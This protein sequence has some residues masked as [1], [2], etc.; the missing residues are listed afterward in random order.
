MNGNLPAYMNQL[1]KAQLEAVEHEG[2][3]LLILAGAGS[4]KTRVITT[5]IAYL[6]E[7]KQYNPASILAVTFTNKAAAEMHNRVTGM[8]PYASGVLV[9]TF[10]SFGAWLLRRNGAAIGM[11]RSFT[12]YDDEDMITLLRTIYEKKKRNELK[13]YA[14]MISL[15]KD[16]ALTPEDNLLPITA[17][18][19]FPSIYAAYNQKLRELGNA[20]FGDLIAR[21]IELLDNNPEIL[22]RLHQRFRTVLVDEYQDSNVAQFELL[23]RL[24]GGGTYLCVVG[25]DD[26][27]IYRFRGAEVQNIIQFPDIFPDTTVIR[28][29]EN[30]RSTEPILD[31]ASSVVEH[32]RGRLGKRLWTRKKGGEKAVVRFFEN[33]EQEVAYCAELVRTGPA[34][35]TAILYRTNAQSRSFEIYFSRHNIPYRL[36]GS[37]SFY[38][39]E[40]VKDALALVTL[41]LNPNDEVAFRRVVNKP[42]RGIGAASL[43]KIIAYAPEARGDLLESC[44]KALSGLS[45]KAARGVKEFLH[46]METVSAELEERSLAE[47]VEGAVRESGILEYHLEQDKISHTQKAMNVEEL[48]NAAA[49]YPNGRE[50]LIEFLEA[51]EL[52]RSRIAAREEEGPSGVT[53]I[54]MHN[55]KGLEFDRVIITG[56]EE[57]LFPGF[58]NE[59]EEDL[60]E[61]RRIFYVSLTRAKEELY[62]TSCRSRR[63]WGK[64]MHFS[65][66]RFLEEI[67]K[68]LLSLDLSAPDEQDNGFKPGTRVYHD[69]YGSGVVCKRWHNGTQTAV[70]V[71]FETGVVHRFIPKYSNLEIIAE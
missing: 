56:L 39:R 30:Y 69:D 33:E 53:L 34:E 62:L 37:L 70:M 12:I 51:V 11:K 17:D 19:E 44:R 10:H 24:A 28:L 23:K 27:S 26:Q 68:E 18:P 50:G 21:C 48:V 57:G 42:T 40:E 20:D 35:S 52:D 46:V 25:D 3:P 5:K 8:V 71:R 32:N 4:G 13:P 54:T 61:E 49:E 7:Q 31:V 22:S 36:V 66:S 67:P 47:F 2:G 45:V 6:I 58:R 65:P 15:A 60:E 14:K 43:R 64:R 41:I 63:L 29:E 38:S 59:L 16:Y 9:R 55:T 1:N